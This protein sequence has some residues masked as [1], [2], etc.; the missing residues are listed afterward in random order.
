MPRIYPIH[1]R[2]LAK[3]FELAG[4]EKMRDKGD[5][6]IYHKENIIRPI[7]IPRYKNVPVFIIEKNLKT[8]Q[9]SRDEYFELLKTI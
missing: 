5:H 4:F 2:K 8:G 6:M 1:Y 9:I 7:V 3:V